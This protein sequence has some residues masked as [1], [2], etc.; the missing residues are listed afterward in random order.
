M[1]G[2]TDGGI[3]PAGTLS[4]IAFFGVCQAVY[5][6]TASFYFEP[7]AHEVGPD[8]R[9]V[10]LDGSGLSG[11]DPPTLEELMQKP[12]A[13]MTFDSEGKRKPSPEETKEY[14][15]KKRRAAAEE[16]KKKRQE[17]K[18]QKA[19]EHQAKEQQAK[20]QQ[21][22]EEEAKQQQQQ[23]QQQLSPQAP[24]PMPPSVP[25]P[26][27]SPSA[28]PLSPSAPPPSGLLPPN[29]FPASAQADA[30]TDHA[31]TAPPHRTTSPSSLEPPS[32][33][34]RLR[35][36]GSL[37]TGG[38]GA[39]RRPS[40]VWAQNGTHVFVTV[41]LTPEERRRVPPPRV[42]IGSRDFRVLVA[43]ANVYATPAT[44]TAAATSASDP[45]DAAAD[46][47]THATRGAATFGD[48]DAAVALALDLYRPLRPELCS[49]HL[50]NRGVVLRL[51]KRAIMHWPRLLRSAAADGKQGVDWARWDHPEAELAVQADAKRDEFRRL[52]A[53]R[54]KEMKELRPRF[55][56]SLRAFSDARARDEALEPSSATE[57]L[58][59]GEAILTHFREERE[60]R[61]ELMGDAPLPA[62]VDEE[63][64][65]RALLQLRELERNGQLKY[66]RNTASWKEWRRRQKERQA[67][68]KAGKGASGDWMQTT[69]S[70]DATSA[71]E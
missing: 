57:L 63:K 4:T 53:A 9:V 7:I 67:R 36:G 62:G 35:D 50:S 55:D 43:A 56:A 54:A 70:A 29:S 68:A 32:M 46:A 66:D 22:Q 41:S 61:H 13:V 64:L 40:Y 30:R 48:D 14:E 5:F 2:P 49:W 39:A 1:P 24:T 15:K 37:R 31:E 51:R 18:E 45:A 71:Y 23:R 25:P 16:E 6:M 38:V 44:P 59:M 10:V 65:E 27:P 11:D 20:E 58:R 33:G 52:N 17:A 42:S 34:M 8:Q 3:L 26:P 60:Q 28:P 19:K 12:A 21:Q 69:Y 47:A